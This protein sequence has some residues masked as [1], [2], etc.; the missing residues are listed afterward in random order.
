MTKPRWRIGVEDIPD[1]GIALEVDSRDTT[2]LALLA[3]AAEGRAGALAGFVS[4][5]VEPW[6]K[7]VDITGT[8]S[9]RI[10]LVCARCLEG[11][12][13]DVDREFS[14]ILARGAADDDEEIEL[15]RSD[16]D[17]SELVGD[18]LDLQEIVR[19]ELMLSLP[20]KPLCRTECKGICPGCG[21]ELNDAE[22]TCAPVVDE[23]WA[24]LAALKARLNKG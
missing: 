8:L 22:C 1:A 9:G 10:P 18:T 12:V 16:L 4:L 19:E 24:A 3:E 7:R 14:Q 6:P 15:R 17:R 2:L 21:A 13:Q 11:Y 23:R 5:Q 20:T